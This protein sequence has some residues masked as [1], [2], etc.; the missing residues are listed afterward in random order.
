MNDLKLLISTERSFDKT[1]NRFEMITFDLN[2]NSIFVTDH[3]SIFQLDNSQ[4]GFFSNIFEIINL[5]YF[6]ASSI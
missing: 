3:L 2:M 5:F 6:K 4:V 1:D